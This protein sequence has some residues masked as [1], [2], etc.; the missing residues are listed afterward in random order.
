MTN[1]R[2]N[3]VRFCIKRAEILKKSL[4]STKLDQ[5]YR[6][7]AAGKFLFGFFYRFIGDKN[8]GEQNCIALFAF[9]LKNLVSVS[10]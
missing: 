2:P 4:Y 6:F 5:L 1:L 9:F 8:F 3:F 10:P 7:I